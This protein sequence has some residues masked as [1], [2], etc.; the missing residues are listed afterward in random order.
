MDYLLFSPLLLKMSALIHMLQN[1]LWRVSW[2]CGTWFLSTAKRTDKNEKGVKVY[3]SL[4]FI[5]K[6]RHLTVYLTRNLVC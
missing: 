1:C 5:Q 3:S 4:L 6:D 2:L